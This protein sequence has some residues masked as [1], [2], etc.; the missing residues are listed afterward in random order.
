[1][2]FLMLSPATNWPTFSEIVPSHLHRTVF[3]FKIQQLIEKSLAAAGAIRD[4]GNYR[5]SCIV[6]LSMSIYCFL[7][8]VCCK[9]LLISSE[10]KD[11]THSMQ[12]LMVASR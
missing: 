11:W 2:G 6:L 3:A 5:L 1:M 8:I 4:H 12:Y 7:L 9:M 10:V